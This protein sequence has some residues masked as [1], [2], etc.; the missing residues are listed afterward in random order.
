MHKYKVHDL[1]DVQRRK[2]K[3]GNGRREDDR[4]VLMSYYLFFSNTNTAPLKVES[5]ETCFTEPTEF[6]KD[7]KGLSTTT[8]ESRYIPPYLHAAHIE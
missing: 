3:K 4:I 5:L 7:F 8:S 1:R 6:R 2:E